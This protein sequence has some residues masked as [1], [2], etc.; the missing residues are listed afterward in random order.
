MGKNLFNFKNILLLILFLIFIN[1]TYLDI[2]FLQGKIPVPLESENVQ[3]DSA[4]SQACITK[5]NEVSNLLNKL[6]ASESPALIPTKAPSSSGTVPL[7]AK[8]YY[9]PF[10]SGSGSSLEW[11]DVA[12]L[13]AY[14]DSNG[15]PNIKSVVFE[16][17]LHIPTG[18]ET[19]SVRLYNATDGRAIS[20]SELN[21]NGNTNS[22]FL[23][24]QP[25]NL[26]YANKLYKI[27]IKT[28]LGYPAVLDQ[29][30]L[31]ITTK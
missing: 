19:A 17:S 9:V 14:V 27:Q 10:G 5:I 25:I 8:E 24:S 6:Q 12:G 26:D 20:G 4:C 2:I 18:N 30:R 16:A 3:N 21:F 31:H 7:T 1:L 13:Q 28:Q 23:A 15:Y 29:S 22:V 11:Q